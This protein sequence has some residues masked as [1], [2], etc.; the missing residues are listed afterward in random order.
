MLGR[1][2]GDEACED[3]V[4]NTR[5]AGT[6]KTLAHAAPPLLSSPLL[7]STHT[8]NVPNRPPRRIQ[9]C[10]PP[11]PKKSHHAFTLTPM[12]MSS[13]KLSGSSWVLR[14]MF[15]AG[16]PASMALLTSYPLLASM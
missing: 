7:S 2:R 12:S 14:L 4:R 1:E 6:A 5:K 9:K 15:S 11:P 16:I 10:K 3:S 8:R 13:A